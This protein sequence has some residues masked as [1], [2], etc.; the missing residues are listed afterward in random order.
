MNE[1]LNGKAPRKLL[2]L[3]EILSLSL[4]FLYS[5]E[6]I[7]TETYV[8]AVGLV[9]LIYFSNFLLGRIHIFD[10]VHADFHWNNHDLQD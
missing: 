3:F 7:Q 1:R 4:I 5:W 6:G 2:F 9:L 8:I 10:S